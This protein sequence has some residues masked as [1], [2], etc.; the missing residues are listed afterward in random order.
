MADEVQ[1]KQQ[2]EDQIQ[3]EKNNELPEGL[4]LNEPTPTEEYAADNEKAKDTLGKYGETDIEKFI[5]RMQSDSTFSR[6][7][8]KNMLGVDH[9]AP[10]ILGKVSNA[11]QEKNITGSLDHSEYPAKLKHEPNLGTSGTKATVDETAAGA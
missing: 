3:A 1:Q 11:R 6:A 10:L 7:V 8:L 5:S 9:D 2:Q 4:K